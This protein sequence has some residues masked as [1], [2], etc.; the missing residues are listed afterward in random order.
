M[1][2]SKQ[3]DDRS[4]ELSPLGFDEA[5]SQPSYHSAGA[6]DLGELAGEVQSF[7]AR[8]NELLRRLNL[9]IEATEKKLLELRRTK[10]RLFP[11]GSLAVLSEPEPAERKTK[12]A[13]K[14]VKT[15]QAS[16]DLL[17]AKESASHV[18]IVSLAGH[19]LENSLASHDTTS[20]V[21]K[22]SE[23]AVTTLG[24]HQIAQRCWQLRQVQT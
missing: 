4:A 19:R 13:A 3:K 10:E 18:A 22:P 23:A 11:E 9:E 2:K 17:P 24:S 14:T 7:I 16:P 6:D 15:P 5:V 8:R 21:A 20:L 12:R 1:R